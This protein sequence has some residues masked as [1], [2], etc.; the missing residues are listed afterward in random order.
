[1]AKSVKVSAAQRKRALQTVTRIAKGME[2]ILNQ[3]GSWQNA[4]E[5]LREF[6]DKNIGNNEFL[7]IYD[8][9]GLA[10]VHS[11][12][13]REGICFNNETELK[14]ARCTEPIAQIYHR[15][16]GEV[17][18]DAASPVY[19]KGK[20]VHAVRLGI[21][22]QASRITNQI[23]ISLLPVVFLGSAWVYLSSFSPVALGLSALAIGFAAVYGHLFNKKVVTAFNE[24]FKVTKSIAKGDLRVLA[25][26]RSNDEL[27]VLAYEVNKV[28]MGM[29]SII[30][31]LAVAARQSDEISHSQAANTQTLAES[32]ENLTA[33][34]EEFSAGAFE[35]I[36][37]MNLAQTKVKEIQA[38]AQSIWNSTREILAL[39]TSAKS[40]SQEGRQAVKEAVNEMGAIFE[41][42]E[43]ANSSILGLAEQAVKIGDIVSVINGIS[44]Q[45]NLLALNAAIEAARAGEHGRGFAVVA[46]EVRKLADDSARSSNQIMELIVQVQEMVNQTVADMSR[47][48]NE[49]D[50]GK[51][52]IQKAG[53]AIAAL[54]EVIYT[55][56]GKVEEN[57]KSAEGLLNQSQV[58]AEVQN[59]ATSIATQFATAAQQAASTVE[60]QMRSVQEVASTATDL[61][62]TSS[63]LNAI[64]KR[65]VW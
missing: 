18:L 13:L 45:T 9:D 7:C 16:T 36:D 31:D 33:V 27:G 3:Y 38:A 41:V 39:A 34:L 56:A 59:N 26:A 30:T 40:T 54:D 43:H 24:G 12:R 57:L 64:I 46:E 32:F 42:T 19:A 17:L 47:G 29:K 50:K 6:I 65:F 53:E 37:G 10:L 25:K 52:V 28:S 63:H 44:T 2:A 8:L 4:V 15:N 1:M 5:P 62:S 48:M 60:Q 14:A 23:I 49:V 20:H 35:Q 22:I 21:P 61:T 55:T 11:N 58:L 51:I